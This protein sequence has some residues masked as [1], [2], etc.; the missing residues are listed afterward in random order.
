VNLAGLLV[1]EGEGTMVH[2]S[3]ISCSP[4]DTVSNSGRFGSSTTLLWELHIYK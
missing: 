3:I 2:Q 4:I 1:L